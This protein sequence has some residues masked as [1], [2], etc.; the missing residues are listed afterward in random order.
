MGFDLLHGDCFAVSGRVIEEAHCPVYAQDPTM[1]CSIARIVIARK[2]QVSI[3]CQIMSTE[4]SSYAQWMRHLACPLV[5]PWRAICGY[6]A[7]VPLSGLNCATQRDGTS[8]SC[9]EDCID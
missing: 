5:S 4:A 7:T 9:R 2:I 3:L 8:V 6:E 1:F